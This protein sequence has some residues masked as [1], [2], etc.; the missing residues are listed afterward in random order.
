MKKI[1]LFVFW[2]FFI[3][4]SI[5]N[6]F[7]LNIFTNSDEVIYCKDDSCSLNNWTEAVKTWIHN[8]QTNNTLSE[9]IQSIIKYLLTFVTIV[10]V[11]YIIYAW[12]KILTS[13]WN[14]EEI[15][16][17]KATIISIFSWILLMWLSYAI[18]KWIISVIVR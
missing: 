2:M 18:V 16:K 14:D 13:W 3:F 6:T 9:Y 17:A 11:I 1:L 8:I 7:A 4:L 15:K 10:A 5:Q 12:F